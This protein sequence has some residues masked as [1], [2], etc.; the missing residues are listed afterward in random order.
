MLRILFG[1]IEAY[2]EKFRTSARVRSIEYQ[3]L[4]EEFYRKEHTKPI[5][6]KHGI[7]AVQNLY[8]YHSFM[9][10]YKIIKLRSPTSILAHYEFS[11]RACL[12][13]TK[14]LPSSPDNHFI[15]KSAIIWN[16]IRA[17]LNIN[18]LSTSTAVVKSRVRKS[19]LTNQH[20]H[21]EIEWFPTHDFNI[22]KLSFNPKNDE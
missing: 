3:V 17:K 20:L 12:M 8:H 9:E 18:D 19:L 15:Y 22:G 21:H 16:T 7:L 4:G 6:K 10:I 11:K 13:Y 1:D 14:I 5:F 2:K